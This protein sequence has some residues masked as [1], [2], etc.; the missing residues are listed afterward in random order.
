MLDETERWVALQQE[1]WRYP[2]QRALATCQRSY[3]LDGVPHEQ[4]SAGRS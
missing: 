2:E 1:D 3:Q 4:L